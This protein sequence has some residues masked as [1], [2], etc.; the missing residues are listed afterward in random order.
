MGFKFEKLE[1]WKLGL[2]YLDLIYEIADRLPPSENFNL[3]S[4]ITRAGTSVTLA[5]AEGSTGQTDTEQTRFLGIGIRSVV[6][7]VAC[8]HII[9]RRRML[10]D[11]DLLRRTY[12]SAQLIF[13]K[14]TAMRKSLDPEQ[15]WVREESALYE[16]VISDEDPFSD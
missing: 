4:Q 2:D 7:T 14:L 9:Y 10:L 1:V 5:I 12:A 6:E 3:R 11:K 16:V 8:L 15:K 13:R